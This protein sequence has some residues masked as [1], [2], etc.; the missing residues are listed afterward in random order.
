[1]GE[2]DLQGLVAIVVHK[3]VTQMY[4]QYISAFS[5]GDFQTIADEIYDIPF[6]LFLQDRTIV[7]NSKERVKSFLVNAFNELEKN[8]YGYSIRNHWEHY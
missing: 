7:Y 4:D 1:M 8:N 2:N 5:K 6:S 3:D